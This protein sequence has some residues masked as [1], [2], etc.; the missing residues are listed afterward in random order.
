MP[1]RSATIDAATSP[2]CD[3]TVRPPSSRTGP[4][5]SSPAARQTSPGAAS[6]AGSRAGDHASSAA[7]TARGPERTSPVCITALNLEHV[8]FSVMGGIREG[9]KS[10]NNGAYTIVSFL[11]VL[12]VMVAPIVAGSCA[13][14]VYRS[15]RGAQQA[16]A[17]DAP[18]ARR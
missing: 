5:A 7:I 6:F 9:E 3:G 14:L 2:E 17:A 10:V 8:V 1:T 18:G 4:V 12:S 16:H 13:I 11:S 15:W